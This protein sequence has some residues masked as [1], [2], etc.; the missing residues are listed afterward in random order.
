MIFDTDIFIWVQRGNVKATNLMESVEE[1]YLS[2][3]TYLEFMQSA[4]NKK[5][6]TSR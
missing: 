6:S 5:N 3:Q 4:Q 2:V 1:P